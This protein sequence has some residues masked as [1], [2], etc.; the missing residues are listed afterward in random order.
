MLGSSKRITSDDWTDQDLLTREEARERLGAEIDAESA[1]L[2]R[3]LRGGPGP[4]AQAELDVRTRRLLAL[5][6][7]C[8]NLSRTGR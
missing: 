5:K 8:A 1:E 4:H 3:L 6:A 2:A 7:A